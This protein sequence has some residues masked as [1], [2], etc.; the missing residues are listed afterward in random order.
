MIECTIEVEGDGYVEAIEGSMIKEARKEYVC[1]ECRRKIK[2]G[3]NFKYLKGRW[4]GK[5]E[6]YIT[7]V[8]CESVRD[9][10]FCMSTYHTLWDDVFEHMNEDQEWYPAKEALDKMT[11]EGRNMFFKTWEK[12]EQ[13]REDD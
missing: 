9:A 8:D 11:E 4:E 3:T 13:W 7:C 6:D 5:V 2:P 10:L 12:Y 1:I